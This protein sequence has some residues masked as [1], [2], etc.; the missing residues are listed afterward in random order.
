MPKLMLIGLVW[1]I[2]LLIS[3]GLRLWG[4]LRPLPL[5]APFSLV[6]L[7]VFLPSILLGIWLVLTTASGVDDGTRESKTFD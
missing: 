6:L 7:I 2:A 3:G 4:E 1:G 5:Q